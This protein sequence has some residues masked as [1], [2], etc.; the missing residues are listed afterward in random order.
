MYVACLFQFTCLFT[1]LL[2]ILSIQINR[3]N[4]A[5]NLW[6]K[7]ESNSMYAPLRG[8]LKTKQNCALSFLDMEIK[9]QF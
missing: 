5:K 8:L 2:P 1:L 4:I 3:Y 9:M 6:I 7:K